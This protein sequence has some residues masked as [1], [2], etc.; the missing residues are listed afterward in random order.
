MSQKASPELEGEE[1]EQ[2]TVHGSLI[3][4]Q[5]DRKK[6]SC[7]FLFLGSIGLEE[8]RGTRCATGYADNQM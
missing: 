6:G 2:G 8:Q 4:G 3:A 7:S 1:G 5:E